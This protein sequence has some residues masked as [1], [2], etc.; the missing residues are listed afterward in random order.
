[1]FS[2]LL[3]LIAD[4]RKL[5]WR[6][7]LYADDYFMGRCSRNSIRRCTYR[8]NWWHTTI[9]R[10]HES[11]YHQEYRYHQWVSNCALSIPSFLFSRTQCVSR[12]SHFNGLRMLWLNQCWPNPY[13]DLSRFTFSKSFS[14]WNMWKSVCACEGAC[15]FKPKDK[16]RT[17][18][19]VCCVRWV[20]DVVVVL[21]YLFRKNMLFVWKWKLCAGVSL[22]LSQC[23]CAYSVY[24]RVFCVCVWMFS[25]DID[26]L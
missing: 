21:I 22:S 25:F 10:R 17:Q 16:Y 2:F 14:A 19:N 12:V 4:T 20:C 7:W 5:F 3:L 15:A 11:R 13:L 26:S 23:V 6:R 9:A 18:C 1:M 24:F 8:R